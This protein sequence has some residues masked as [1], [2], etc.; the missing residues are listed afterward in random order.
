MTGKK[1]QFVFK[2]KGMQMKDEPMKGDAFWPA[3]DCVQGRGCTWKD[4]T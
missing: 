4:Y 3:G 2:C 1:I